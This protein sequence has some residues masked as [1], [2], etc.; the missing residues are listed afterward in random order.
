MKVSSVCFLILSICSL[1]TPAPAVVPGIRGSP[2]SLAPFHDEKDTPYSDSKCGFDWKRLEKNY[3]YHRH[4]WKTFR[5]GNSSSCYNMTVQ[6]SCFCSPFWQGPFHVVVRDDKVVSPEG[7]DLNTTNEFYDM[8]YQDCIA[9]CPD[10]GPAVCTV[11]YAPADKGSY[12]TSIF[13]NP[14]K[15]ITDRQIGWTISNLTFCD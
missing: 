4:I 14:T 1:F 6:R 11:L 12:I 2:H 15:F 10:D 8:V 13:V 9:V 3:L 5:G 7:F